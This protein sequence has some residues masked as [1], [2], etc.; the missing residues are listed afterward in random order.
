VNAQTFLNDIW[1][2]IRQE[3]GAIAAIAFAKLAEHPDP[4]IRDA[5]AKALCDAVLQVKG[6][7]DAK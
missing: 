2:L 4:K 5:V 6:N 3:P 1:D 7:S